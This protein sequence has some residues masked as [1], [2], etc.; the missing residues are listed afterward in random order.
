MI[1]VEVKATLEG[2]DVARALTTLGLPEDGARPYEIWF[3]DAPD[4]VGEPRLPAADLTPDPGA[5][6]KTETV[7]RELLDRGH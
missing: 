7:I 3:F 5:P 1:G 4:A 6:P 2:E